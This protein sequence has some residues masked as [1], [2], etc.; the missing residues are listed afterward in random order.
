M[1]FVVLSGRFL[2]RVWS[3]HKMGLVL[4][5]C[6]Q[7]GPT[8]RIEGQEIAL[9]PHKRR[10]LFCR[11]RD[12]WKVLNGESVAIRYLPG[13]HDCSGPVDRRHDPRLEGSGAFLCGEC[14]DEAKR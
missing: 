5:L 1:T 11:I 4:I 8:Y 7:D 6:Y 10:S 14:A 13:C 9:A 3:I 2:G 12:A